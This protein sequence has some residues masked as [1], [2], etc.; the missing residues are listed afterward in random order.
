LTSCIHWLPA[1]DLT[2]AVRGT[3]LLVA[4]DVQHLQVRSQLETQ[5]S[6][7]RMTDLVQRGTEYVYLPGQTETLRFTVTNDGFAPDPTWSQPYRTDGDGSLE[8]M[9]KTDRYAVSVGAAI[10]SDQ[11][12]LYTDDREC[13]GDGTNC[14]LFLVVADLMTG[15]APTDEFATLALS[16]SRN[17]RRR[18]E[19]CES[20]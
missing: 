18:N 7:A 20:W 9:W 16:N 8:Q 4:V 11:H 19:R 10:V 6:S 12:R 17:P 5:L 1:P 14:R 15:R 3:G 13:D 2:A